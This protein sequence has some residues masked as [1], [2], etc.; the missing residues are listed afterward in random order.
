MVSVQVLG[1]TQGFLFLTNRLMGSGHIGGSPVGIG[2]AQR[3]AID[4]EMS[5]T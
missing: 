5:M 2:N 4:V 1:G 3:P